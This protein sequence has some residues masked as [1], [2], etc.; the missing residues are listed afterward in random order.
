[1]QEF[2]IQEYKHN[3]TN[4]I[5]IMSCLTFNSFLDNE[6]ASHSEMENVKL[7]EHVCILL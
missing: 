6:I 1:M 4:S 5:E 7:L 2:V 3:I